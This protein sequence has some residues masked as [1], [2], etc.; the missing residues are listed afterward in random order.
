LVT[1]TALAPKSAAAVRSSSPQPQPISR[2]RLPS[3]KTELATDQLELVLLGL[4][5]V[6]RVAPVAA[7]VT[8]G[9]SESGL[10][11]LVAEIVMLLG[12]FARA[13]LRLNVDEPAAHVVPHAGPA[14]ADIRLE[15]F[16]PADEF[17]EPFAVPPSIHVGLTQPE[18]ALQ[19]DT[20]EQPIVVDLDVKG[21][22]AVDRDAG[23]GEQL[24][25]MR[26]ES[27]WHR[28]WPSNGCTV[29]VHGSR[30]AVIV[31]PSYV[32]DAPS[33]TTGAHRAQL[34]VAI[35]AIILTP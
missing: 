29:G 26:P 3:R 7:R 28:H 12:D 25:R 4:V 5:D 31:Q 24:F 2:R 14:L 32:E 22:R 21:L 15:M 11:Q 23:G 1:P 19:Q 30:R 35:A 9:G 6:G 8:H 33:T 13:A 16:H 27:A 18:R 10:E 17:V 20:T 34:T